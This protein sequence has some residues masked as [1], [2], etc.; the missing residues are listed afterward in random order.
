MQPKFDHTLIMGK[1]ITGIAPTWKAL[2]AIREPTNSYS[3]ANMEKHHLYR[4]VRDA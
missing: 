4:N 1:E 2:I 3:L